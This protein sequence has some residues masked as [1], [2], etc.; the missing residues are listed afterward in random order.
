MLDPHL[1]R[2]TDQFIHEVYSFAISNCHD[3]L[4]YD[5]RVVYVRKE[6]T[7]IFTTDP[8]V[9]PLGFS[10]EVE[11]SDESVDETPLSVRS[12]NSSV[13]EILDSDDEVQVDQG[14]EEVVTE[15][16][17]EATLPLTESELHINI[18]DDFDNPRPGP[19][20][21]NLRNVHVAKRPPHHYSDSESDLDVGC[22]TEQPTH[23]KN[24]VMD[25]SD[26]GESVQII[27]SKKA[28]RE[29]TP[30]LIDLSDT[31]SEDTP[32]V[33]HPKK[34]KKRKHRSCVQD[35]ESFPVKK[36]TST[37]QTPDKRLDQGTPVE[38]SNKGSSNAK[39]EVKDDSPVTSNGSL[40]LKSVI[41][42][43]I[44]NGKSSKSLSNSVGDESKD[45]VVRKSGFLKS[46]ISSLHDAIGGRS[47]E[48]STTEFVTVSNSDQLR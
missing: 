33:R 8:P 23:I 36:D 28:L 7:K 43:V 30:V 26:S 25:D 10:Y 39:P 17:T 40:V 41:G 24:P 11:S 12:N 19:S 15:V 42:D 29:R 5:N 34:H 27:G 37:P 4:D 38:D 22:E 45:P 3:M 18:I 35:C 16:V 21:L 48:S 31:D 6:Q 46:V 44:I 14:R 2:R 13:I 47:E 32:R 20:G 9:P 1:V